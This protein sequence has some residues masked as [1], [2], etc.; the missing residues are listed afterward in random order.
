MLLSLHSLLVLPFSHFSF[1]LLFYSTI[2]Y[3]ISWYL[4]LLMP[5][6]LFFLTYLPSWFWPFTRLPYIFM[7]SLT[8]FPWSPSSL[9][10][11]SFLSFGLQFM[12]QSVL[13]ILLDPVPSSPFLFL[14]ISYFSPFFSFILIFWIHIFL[15]SSLLLLPYF[16]FFVIFLHFLLPKQRGLI[17]TTR[18]SAFHILSIIVFY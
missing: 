14:S 1:L 11:S 17:I 13:P 6:F 4:I 2:L 16:S 15:C 5:F 3:L 18:P 9:T 8:L 7:R 10:F 12:F